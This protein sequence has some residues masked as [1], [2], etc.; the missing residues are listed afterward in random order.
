MKR[1][2]LKRA[3]AVGF[4]VARRLTCKVDDPVRVGLAT[5]GYEIL[6][7]DMPGSVSS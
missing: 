7:L 3:D 2:V 5:L 4:D 1:Q 6:V